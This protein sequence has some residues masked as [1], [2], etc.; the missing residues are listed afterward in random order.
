MNKK[1]TGDQ[2]IKGYSEQALASL[3]TTLSNASGKDFFDKVCHHLTTALAADYAF[4][5]ELIEGQQRVRLVGGVGKGQSM[6]LPL[7]YDLENTPCETIIAQPFCIFPAAVQE[8][9][10]KD[11]ML[12]EMG[13][14][15]YMGVP[16]VSSSGTTLGLLVVMDGLEAQDGELA[17]SLLKIFSDR[18]AAE[19]ERLQL[20]RERQSSTQRLAALTDNAFP[21]GVQEH[22]LNGVITYTNKAM[23]SIYGCKPGDLI[24]R[25]VWDSGTTPK[26]RLAARE[27]FF[28][29]KEK[30]PVPE[31]FLLP[32]VLQD[33]REVMLEIAWNYQFDSEGELTGFV[34]VIS[35]VTARVTAEQELIKSESRFRHLVENAVDCIHEINLSGEIISMNQAGL[36][37]LGLEH[38]SDII[39]KKYLDSVCDEDRSRI[40]KLLGQAYLGTTSKFEFGAVVDSHQRVFTSSFIPI[41]EE[42]GK[43]SRLM[44]ITRDISHHMETERQRRESEEK[45]SKSF[46]GHPTAM[47]IL[48]LKSGERVEINDS[49][50]SLTGCSREEMLHT[51]FFDNAL[52][53]E[54]K[55]REAAVKK[56][57][58]EG[59]LTDL[60]MRV[61]LKS[62][63]SRTWLGNA[64]LMDLSG[65]SLAIVSFVDITESLQ[66]QEALNE[67]EEKFSKAFHFHPSAMQILNLE[68]GERL[69]I[70]QQ[71]LALYGV[72]NISQL[73]SNIFKAN[74]WVESAK[75]SESVQQLL[76]DG[77]L[78][79]Y[80]IEIFDPDG[81]TRYLVS[82][83]AM[84]DI[85]DGN[86][87]IISY[88]DITEN[89]KLALELDQHRD[90]LEERV[91][92]R[93]QQL[94]E[95]SEKAESAN[96][97]KST[98]LANMSHE[99][100][101]PMNAIIGLTH[102]LHRARPTPEQAHQLDKIDTS[103]GHLLSIINDILDISK[104]D[105]GKLTL[106][107]TDFNLNNIFGQVQSLLTPQARAKGLNIEVDTSDVP[108]GLMGD[109][110]RV[111]QAL[112]NYASNAVKF[113]E[114]GNIC[115]SAKKLEERDDKLLLRFEV[116]DTGI[117]FDP[118]K[119]VDLFEAFEQADNTTTRKYGGS[120]LG[121]AITRRLAEL[122]GGEVGAE[123]A[124][125]KGSKFWFTAW[126]GHGQVVSPEIVSDK[127]SGAEMRLRTHHAGDRILLVEDNAINR[128]VAVAL[129]S[130][131]YLAVDTA[132]D[133]AQAVSMVSTTLYDLVLM[134][135]QMPV[136]DGLQATRVIRSMTGS[137]VRSGV[138]YAELPILAMTANVFEENRQACLDAGIQDFV[139]KPVV[140]ENLFSMLVKWLPREAGAGLPET[141]QKQTL[142]EM[143][144][145][146]SDQQGLVNEEPS[147]I[148]PGALT[149]IF[150]DDIA[151]QLAILQK[152]ATQSEQV[153]ADFEAAYAQRD[154]EKVAFQTHKLKSSARTVGAN[155]LAD[156]CFTL[157]VSG[158]KVDWDEI[159][160]LSP[161]MRPA[162]EQVKA[163]IDRL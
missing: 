23:D 15:A 74:R 43:V 60:P 62:G 55:Q 6:E 137:M 118:D 92:E 20:E 39:G 143:D 122:M 133:G 22:D 27:H 84:L 110:T 96:R 107:N 95:A 77:F 83:A 156:L 28:Y 81:K 111:R 134:D 152:F 69:E 54:E 17:K 117:G 7:E 148:D 93:T 105:A 73:N 59:R 85:L 49:Y 12:A 98:F 90:H 127:G 155:Y 65:R 79:N 19:L 115:L 80:P 13:I 157:E 103:A 76:R 154:A 162:L 9:F 30:R 51:S 128:E 58:S 112:L 89:K 33:G 159:D 86:F 135:I 113:T 66:T 31:L 91:R 5:G 57:A 142:G 100:R 102:L 16:L 47:Q 63:E 48:D 108:Y 121:L 151:A 75:Q 34:S 140:P 11:T 42:D 147:P 149:E 8:L 87:A 132:Q 82:N 1:P 52:W 46:Y 97:A 71:C 160:R 40:E 35:D 123:S 67:S 29:L 145:A 56:L 144:L 14:A 44:G 24:G 126:L 124:P 99:I 163:Y 153:V 4:I 18:V 138:S 38:E 161:L 120:G 88:I 32:K 106:E 101:T 64:A 3:T 78:H 125:G 131:A 141:S 68:S 116:Q 25:Y 146:D 37:M 36:E 158:R 72:E 109:Q 119:L 94:A 45:F 139:A 21:S 150:G 70:N 10:P 41:A 104:I 114:H 53:G 61:R 136:M 26:T 50:C 2:R 129:L 130:S